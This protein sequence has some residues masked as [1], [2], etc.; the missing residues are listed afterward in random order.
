MRFGHLLTKPEPN[1]LRQQPKRLSSPS[2]RLWVSQHPMTRA[3]VKL[4]GPCFKTD[5]MEQGTDTA[6]DDISGRIH[7]CGCPAPKEACRDPNTSVTA[8]IHARSPERL[9]REKPRRLFPQPQLPP[10]SQD[11]TTTRCSGGRG[12]SRF[13]H[14]DVYCSKCDHPERQHVINHTNP[15]VMPRVPLNPRPLPFVYLRTIS[16]TLELS[17]QSSFQLS[18]TVLVRYRSRRHI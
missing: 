1:I 15:T 8:V 18:L 7:L 12:E 3:H 5:R 2:F 14:E 11:Q 13:D 9:D 16:R 10:G 6:L 4:L 17:L